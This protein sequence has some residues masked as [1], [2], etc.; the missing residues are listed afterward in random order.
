MRTVFGSIG[1]GEAGPG[2]AITGFDGSKPSG[3]HRETGSG[4]EVQD[5]GVDTWEIIRI[6]CL[7]RCGG[8]AWRG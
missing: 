5:K 4:V 8:G 1:I 2:G 3:S 6:E 7:Q